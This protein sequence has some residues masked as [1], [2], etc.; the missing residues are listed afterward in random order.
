MI[1]PGAFENLTFPEQKLLDWS[2][3]ES[4]TWMRVGSQY[5]TST[6]GCSYGTPANI[7]TD[8]GGSVAKWAGGALALDGKIYALGHLQDNYLII[9]TFNDTTATTGSVSPTDPSSNGSA[10]SPYTNCLYSDS[11]DGIYKFNVATS[12]FSFIS[13]GFTGQ[14]QILGAAQNG[15]RIYYHGINSSRKM[16]YYDVLTDSVV[17]TGVTWSGDRITGCLSWNNK[18][19]LGG[20][21]SSPNFL[22][23]DVNAN[24]ATTITGGAAIGDDQYRN[25]IQ[26]FDGFLYTFG[27]FGANRIKRVNPV[28]NEVIDV[29]TMAATNYNFNDYSIGAD[30][31]IYCVGQSST[32]GIYD[33]RDNTFSTKTMPGSSYEGIVMGIKGDLYAIPWNSNFVAQI[34]IQNNLRVLRAIQEYN[35]IICRHL[36]S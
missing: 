1:A 35:G 11:D 6:N 29:F 27:G 17:D 14:A 28:T 34:P 20:G 4:L 16:W 22:V 8:F 23:Y 9:D 26:Y 5:F 2:N 13:K 33:P 32:L 15:R 24:S 10:Y 25:F 21:G 3:N 19:Y 7:S 12:A 36:P 30:G 18:F 31:K